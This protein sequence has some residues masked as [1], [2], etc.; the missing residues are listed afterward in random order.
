VPSLRICIYESTISYFTSSVEPL[1]A[2]VHVEGLSPFLEPP[3]KV[4]E[5]PPPVLIPVLI[6][7][8]SLP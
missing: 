1:G 7:I 6:P 8:L 3:I 5:S 4:V 2:V